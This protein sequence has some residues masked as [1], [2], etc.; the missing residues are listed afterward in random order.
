[1]KF[2]IVLIVLYVLNLNIYASSLIEEIKKDK[3]ISDGIV[4]FFDYNKSSYLISVGIST[5]EDNSSIKDKINSIKIAKL[6][7]QRGL[8]NFI[9]SIYIKTEEE[10]ITI[11]KTIDNNRTVNIKYLKKIKEKGRG[12]LSEIIDIGKWETDNEYFYALGIKI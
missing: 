6:I 9:H 2:K 5:V 10:L 11:N 1:M 7:A 4:S 8:N 12:I 3:L